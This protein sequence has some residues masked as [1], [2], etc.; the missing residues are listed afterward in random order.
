MKGL[1]KC[2]NGRVIHQDE[3]FYYE[4]TEKDYFWQSSEIQGVIKHVREAAEE[5]LG[6]VIEIGCGIAAI[7]PYL[8]SSIEYTGTDVSEFA[9][10]RAK[11]LHA[12]DNAKFLHAQADQLPFADGYF[13]FALA[14]NVI[15]HC[16]QP[17]AALDE[18]YRVIRPGGGVFI[19]GP[20]LDLPF[21]ISNGIRHRSALYKNWIRFL[22][23]LDY[24]GRMFGYLKFRIVPQNITEATG[25]YEKPDDDLRYYCSAYEV[26]EYLKRKGARLV[27]INQLNTAPGLK[28]RLKKFMT[29]LP[30]MK[31]YGR[32]LSVILK[33]P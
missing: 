24:L 20:N 11:E 2:Y 23:S 25:R 15:E 27:Y 21:S 10:H 6:R 30:G 29:R 16:R 1:Q 31:Y 5:G 4:L 22:R 19:T 18:L 14:F 3:K 17:K 32:G 8:P 33:K 26:V 7:I 9:L 28:G 13:D 12:R